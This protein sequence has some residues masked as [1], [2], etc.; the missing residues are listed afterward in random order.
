VPKFK[1]P[2]VEDERDPPAEN[3]EKEKSDPSI[4]NKAQ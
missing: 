4:L 1:A 2:S 3:K